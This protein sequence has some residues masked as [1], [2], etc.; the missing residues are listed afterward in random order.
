MKIIGVSGFIGAGKTTLLNYLKE[1][2]HIVVI[3]AD[4]ISK[5]V[6]N[7]EQVKEFLKAKIPSA[8]T[9]VGEI[10]RQQV[11]TVVFLDTKLNDEFTSIMWPL[12]SARINELIANDY[13][14]ETVVVVEAAIISGLA[15]NFDVTILLQK[16]EEQRIDLVVERDERDI[17]EIKS[18]S[19]YQMNRVK[20]VQF[21]YILKNND[22]IEVFYQNIDKLIDK[23][24]IRFLKG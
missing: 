17:T 9:K 6:I 7:H 3:D 11:R 16:D 14:K 15:V 18:I 2:Y 24:S 13:Q 5:D 4:Q 21:D 1:K 23:I 10:D 20:D 19:A 22:N 12:I 8:I